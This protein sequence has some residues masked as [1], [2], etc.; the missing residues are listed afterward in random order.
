MVATETPGL[1]E[2]YKPPL[3]QLVGVKHTTVG[4]RSALRGA[5]KARPPIIVDRTFD[6]DLRG[7][8][9]GVMF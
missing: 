2:G 3:C 4:G 7:K 6:R 5:L 8:A 9:G 1:N